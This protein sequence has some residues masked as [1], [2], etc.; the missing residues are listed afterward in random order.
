MQDQ[1]QFFK[2]SVLNGNMCNASSTFAMRFIA[3]ILW[4]ADQLDAGMWTQI[5]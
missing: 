3:H 5:S 4:G 2:W 1:L